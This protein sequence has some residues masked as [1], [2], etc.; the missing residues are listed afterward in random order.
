MVSTVALEAST[1]C[2]PCLGRLGPRNL[3]A[4]DFHFYSLSQVRMSRWSRGRIVLVGDAGYAVSL[5]TGQATSV[6]MVGAYVLASELALHK[7]DLVGGIAAYED[8]LRAN[9]TRNQDIA[10]EQS[11]QADERTGEGQPAPVGSIPDFGAL[12]L[13]FDLKRYDGGAGG[14]P[15]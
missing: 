3:R 10:L 14:A 4:T 12:T 2:D 5:G 8:V 1:P 13:P 7:E 15:P 6:A 11:A 9:V